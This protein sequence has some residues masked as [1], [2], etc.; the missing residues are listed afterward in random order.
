MDTF[1]LEDLDDLTEGDMVIIG[2]PSDYGSIYEEGNR[3]APRV[4]REASKQYSGVNYDRTKNFYDFNVL[5]FGD[6]SYYNDLDSFLKEIKRFSNEIYQ[7]RAYPIYIG[8]NHLI[9]YPIIQ[10]LDC[11]KHRIGVIWIDSHLDFMDEYPDGKKYTIATPLRRIMEIENFRPDNIAI[12]GI[13]GNTQ[14][15]QEIKDARSSIPSI[16]SMDYIEKIGLD[17]ILTILKNQFNDVDY[18]HVSLDIDSIDPAFAPGV[19]VP[20]P[21]GFTS[22]EI[23]KIIRFLSKLSHSLDIVEYNPK[24]DTSQIT[25][26]LICTLIIENITHKMR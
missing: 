3:D 23:L 10:G 9:T 26:K 25:A 4:I 8:G 19:S 12:L 17:K 18:L 24:R 20:E 2:I 11:P 22:R 5:D 7:K 1:K 14:G 6:I 21:G 13:H 15:T 16:Y